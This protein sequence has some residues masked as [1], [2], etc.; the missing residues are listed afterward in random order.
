MKKITLFLFSLFCVFSLTVSAQDD[1][2][3]LAVNTCGTSWL[4]DGTAELGNAFLAL[5]IVQMVLMRFYLIVVLMTFRL[6][7]VWL[8]V[9][10]I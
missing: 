9:N 3:D 10:H 1:G 5:P 8:N 4:C 7:L 2:G 6:M